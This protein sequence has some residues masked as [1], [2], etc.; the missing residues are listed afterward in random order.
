MWLLVGLGNPGPKYAATRHNVGFRVIDQLVER[1]RAPS[2]RTKLGA[3]VG[4]AQIGTE[5]VLLCKPMEFMNTSGQAVLRVAQFW[6]IDPARTVVVHDEL[7]LPFGRLKL[8]PGGGHG[9]HNGLRSIIAEWGTSDFARVRFGISRP[10]S[11]EFGAADYVLSEFKGAERKELPDLC[12]RA[13]EA[14][15]T[16]VTAGLPVAMNR[17]NGKAGSATA[18]PK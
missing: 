12:S 9:G 8:M 16:I 2:L 6:K 11:P 1:N 3:E 5:R 10:V 7:D 13:A 4:E 18:D 15:E 17:F 14:M